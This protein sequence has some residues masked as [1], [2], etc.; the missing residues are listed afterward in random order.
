MEYDDASAIDLFQSAPAALQQHTV[1][2]ITGYLSAIDEV[3]AKLQ[4]PK[5]RNLL[6]IK[7]SKR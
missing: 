6:E 3:I 7:S 1:Q 2:T 5:L 4:H